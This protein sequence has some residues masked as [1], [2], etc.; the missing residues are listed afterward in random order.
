MYICLYINAHCQ[1][2]IC[3]LRQ[4]PGI[5]I[6]FCCHKSNETYSFTKFLASS[7]SMCIC[8]HITYI[9][10]NDCMYTHTH[11]RTHYHGGQLTAPYVTFTACS[12]LHSFLLLLLML[13]YGSPGGAK[14]LASQPHSQP[15]V[16]V[17]A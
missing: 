10:T 9:W 3:V 16:Y 6:N 1:L 12:C 17:Y 7:I 4:S 5:N 13:K 8:I 15:C 2:A 11:A 14:V